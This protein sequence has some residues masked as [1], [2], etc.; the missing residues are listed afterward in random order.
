[1]TNSP[2]QLTQ[3][4]STQDT[5]KAP[6]LEAGGTALELPSGD[7]R[8]C[9]GVLFEVVD[10]LREGE[11]FPHA[12]VAQHLERVLSRH[13]QTSLFF[14]GREQKHQAT[15][16]IKDAKR[17]AGGLNEA[18][19]VAATAALF[20]GDPYYAAWLARGNV[21]TTEVPVLQLRMDPSDEAAWR[22]HLSNPDN[23]NTHWFVD[24]ML[25]VGRT[26]VLFEHKYVKVRDIGDGTLPYETKK[27]VDDQRGAMRRALRLL[28]GKPWM[29]LMRT[30]F[31]SDSLGRSKAEGEEP[32]DAYMRR[33]HGEFL[34]RHVAAFCRM[35]D[36][37]SAYDK[38]VAVT[39]VGAGVHVRSM[40]SMRSV[41]N[42]RLLRTDEAAATAAQPR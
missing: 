21:L 42:A 34:D 39:I 11:P 25:T 30:V 14:S 5:T 1:M 29:Q 17:K 36:T 10:A 12:V 27:C 16:G 38:V 18:A 9:R 26:A 13:M 35:P 31:G 33:T 28:H 37:A 20:V 7:G 4:T 15:A 3:A 32:V 40:C 8:P 19:L 2:A 24:M 22:E 6:G 23:V 41:P